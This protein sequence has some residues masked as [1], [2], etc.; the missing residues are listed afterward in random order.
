MNDCKHDEI[1]LVRT[2]LI[3]FCPPCGSTLCQVT[4]AVRDRHGK[5]SGNITQPDWVPG[6]NHPY[7][8][9]FE[10]LDVLAQQIKSVLN[11]E[12]S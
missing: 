12:A 1:N 4:G 7:D 5:V 9:I 6:P 10:L 11:L 8:K 2:E 3:H